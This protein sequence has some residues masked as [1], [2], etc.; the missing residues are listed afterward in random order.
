MAALLLTAYFIYYPRY[1]SR[2]IYKA[3]A[4][5]NIDDRE[6]A[7]EQF[8]KHLLKYP[9]DYRARISLANLLIELGKKPAAERILKRILLDSDLDKEAKYL[10]YIQALA[11]LEELWQEKCLTIQHNIDRCV[12]SLKYSD[13]YSLSDTLIK[14]RRFSPAFRYY[15]GEKY[16][17]SKLLFEQALVLY[18]AAI[19]KKAFIA[20]LLNNGKEEF[21]IN[22]VDS[23]LVNQSGD[24]KDVVQKRRELLSYELSLLAHRYFMDKKY[25]DAGRLFFLARKQRYA[26]LGKYDNEVARLQYNEALA[27]IKQ[28]KLNKGT[29][30]LSL[31][32]DSIPEYKPDQIESIIKN[33]SKEI[34]LEKIDRLMSI[35]EERFK[36]GDWLGA[37]SAYKKVIDYA[38]KNGFSVDDEIIAMCRYN[39]AMAYWNESMYDKAWYLLFRIQQDAPDFEPKIIDEKLDQLMKIMSY[40]R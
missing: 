9:N 35:A 22:S 26:M 36:N 6:G 34:V 23:F 11:M 7:V 4:L 25:S 31:L 19:T 30:L 40:N 14:L 37:V 12:D 16:S 13:A 2:Y 18:N 24:N 20:I 33:V 10:D 28:G 27:L 17:L 21:I 38:L 5:L 29:K 8:K 1:R 32:K 39:S 3:N 15:L